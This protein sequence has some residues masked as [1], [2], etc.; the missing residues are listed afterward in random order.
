M[1]EQTKK[2]LCFMFGFSRVF[3]FVFSSHSMMIMS[4]CECVSVFINNIFALICSFDRS[5]LSF[6][7][8]VAVSVHSFSFL[9]A[10]FKFFLIYATNYEYNMYKHK[11]YIIQL[12]AN[13]SR[14]QNFI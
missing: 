10:R 2:T 5:V 7:L 6:L 1:N 11:F 13:R 3:A 9:L 8:S 14:L 12:G 4:A